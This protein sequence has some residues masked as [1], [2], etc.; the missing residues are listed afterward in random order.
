M[1]RMVERKKPLFSQLKWVCFCISGIR[2]RA[3]LRSFA[4]PQDHRRNVPPEVLREALRTPLDGVSRCIFSER[5]YLPTNA[6]SA[7][8]T[9]SS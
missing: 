8:K 5:P 7:R 2:H 9:L 4:E 3:V 6:E 1:A